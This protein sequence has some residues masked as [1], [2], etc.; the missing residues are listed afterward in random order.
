MLWPS[1]GSSDYPRILYVFIQHVNLHAVPLLPTAMPTKL[2]H[3]KE[4]CIKQWMLTNEVNTCWRSECLQAVNTHWI[5]LIQ[6]AVTAWFSECLLIQCG[7]HWFSECLLIQWAVNDLV[8]VH[9]SGERS[10]IQ[11][12]WWAVNDSVMI[13]W[14]VTDSVNVQWWS[15]AKHTHAKVVIIMF[16]ETFVTCFVFNCLLSYGIGN[17]DEITFVKKLRNEGRGK[18]NKWC[19]FKWTLWSH[20][21]LFTLTCSCFQFLILHCQPLGM[22]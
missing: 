20:N 4:Q 5:S 19:H 15:H 2:I 14:A 1:H 13:W 8:N 3:S 21:N 7:S 11:W 10:L 12:I 18:R 6:W 22:C 17:H 9:W 16:C